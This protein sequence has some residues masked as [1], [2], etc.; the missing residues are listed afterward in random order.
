[1]NR[2]VLTTLILLG[3][4]VRINVQ[5]VV[6]LLGGFHHLLQGGEFVRFLIGLF[7]G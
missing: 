4:H 5:F 3:V 2:L 1:M 6:V 7:A